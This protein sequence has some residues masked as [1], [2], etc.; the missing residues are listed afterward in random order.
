MLDIAEW[1]IPESTWEVLTP[2]DALLTTLAIYFHDLGMLV[3]EDEYEARHASGVAAFRATAFDGASG[4]DYEARVL[5]LGADRADRFVYQEFIRE[6][7]G[8]RVAAWITGSAPQELGIA[9]TSMKEVSSLLDPLPRP[10]R[11]DLGLVC[12]SHHRDDL[13]RT[14]KYPVSKPY[15]PTAAETANV[16][17]AAIVLRTSDLLHVTSDRTPSLTY[18]LISPADPISQQEWAKQS[19]V[20]NVRPKPGQDRDGNVDQHAPRDT[21]E[22]FADFS[23]ENGFFG[24]TAYLAYAQTQLQQAHE[25]ALAAQRHHG[26]GYAFPWRFI[27]E[28][29]VRT[30]GFLRNTY[31]FTFDQ[32]RVLDLLT[33][34]TLYNNTSVVLRELIQN[35]LD[36]IRLQSL[37]AAGTEEHRGLVDVEWDSDSRR[38]TITDNGTGM[39]QDVIE[40]HLLTVGSSKYQD[41]HFKRQY[42]TFSPI[43]RFGIG[44]LSTFMIADAVTITTCHPDEPEARR[45][46]LRSVHG[47]YL[48]RLLDKDTDPTAKAVGPHGTRVELDL[49]PSADIGDVATI[50]QRW[51]VVPRCDVKLHVN[52]ENPKAIGFGSIGDA[53]ASWLEEHDYQVVSDS[54][55]VQNGSIKVV[56]RSDDGLDLAFAVRWSERF[57]EWSLVS[58]PRTVRERDPQPLG[59]SVEGIRVEAGTPGYRSHI[60]A[61]M[62]DATGLGAPK[63]DVARQV[64][65]QTPERTKAI[66]A[67]YKMYLDFI[68]AEVRALVAERNFSVTWA[69]R[70]ARWLISPLLREGALDQDAFDRIAA[71]LPSLVVDEGGS[72]RLASPGEV[73]RA[74]G[75]WTVQSAFHESAEAVLRE[76]PSEVSVAA[77]S[78]ALGVEGFDAPEGLLVASLDAH[79]AASR[80]LFHGKEAV[81]IVIRRD[82]RRVDFEWRPGNPVQPRWLDPLPDLR[83]FRELREAVSDRYTYDPDRHTITQVRVACGHIDIAGRRD[84]F[85]VRSGPTLYLLPDSPLTD[86]INDLLSTLMANPSREGVTLRVFLFNMIRE[87][88]GGG[89]SPSTVDAPVVR[90]HIERSAISSKVPVRDILPQFT[91]LDDLTQAFISTR[92]TIFDPRAWQRNVA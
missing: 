36:A 69:A 45:L 77:L 80:K 50:L 25:W 22:V 4:S 54:S 65:E 49:R 39:T 92:G 8:E 46:S 68:T 72:R 32:H 10:F 3:T 7:H 59:L 51:I 42:P 57:R 62:A 2:A 47:R 73:N 41:P 64:L 88:L 19:A 1:L 85:A 21:I 34:H 89:A 5:A 17:Y 76:L 55:D 79:S 27:D 78:E 28:S 81:S 12:E 67:A 71:E 16:Q 83:D 20:A 15:G 61:A 82:Q 38:L 56:E 37:T 40:R 13:D 29:Q 6:H 75:F 14:D 43:S 18:R 70:E 74:G 44:V 52:G 31:E 30:T 87:L 66:E 11:D 23:E 60:V 63:T 91:S 84:E 26:S 48:V 24:L 90:D 9:T 86:Y 53:L 33:G 58:T 35:S